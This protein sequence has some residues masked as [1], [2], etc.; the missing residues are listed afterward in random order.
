MPRIARHSLEALKQHVALYDVV[1]PVVSLKRSGRNWVGL[2]P[3]SNEKTPS[4]YVLTDKNIFKCFSSGLAGDAIRFLQETDK[5][6]FVEAIEVLAERFGFQL[7]YESGGEG[8]QEA[9]SRSRDLVAL[10]DYA[11][12]YYHRCLLADTPLSAQTRTYWE[13]R[14][15]LPM[16]LAQTFRI[17]L[18]PPDSPRLV[19]RLLD[20]GF[21]PECLR[22]SGL[23]Y[24]REGAPLPVHPRQWRQRF[25][26]RLMIP[27]RDYLSRTVAFT[28][29]Q[30]EG[31]TPEDDPARE[32]KYINSPETALFDKGRILFNLD[33]A[34][35]ALDGEAAELTW[36][37]GQLDALRCSSVGLRSVVAPQGTAVTEAQLSL[38]K[39]YTRRHRFILDGDRAGRQ[40]A[41]RVLPKALALH[42]DLSVVLLADGE[43]PDS[44][45]RSDPE[46]ALRAWEQTA[47][48]G[49]VYAARALVASA[50]DP[51]ARAEGLQQFFALLLHAPEHSLQ[52]DLLEQALPALPLA[53]EALRRDFEH[54]RAAQGAQRITLHSVPQAN[55]GDPQTPVQQGLTSAEEDLVW[56]FLH[57]PQWAELLSNYLDDAWLDRDTLA[58]RL[59]AA[60]LT[61]ARE[62][63]WEA[64]DVWM[65]SLDDAA[66]R[67]WLFSL[68]ARPCPA[69][70]LREHAQSALQALALRHTKARQQALTAQLAAAQSPEAVQALFEQRRSLNAQCLKGVAIELPP[71]PEGLLT[72]AQN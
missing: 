36:V 56:Q 14:R 15:G 19:E 39:R 61:E 44:L 3:F 65:N 8:R 26:G 37:E 53:P 45:L 63:L 11:A 69:E 1:S 64:P 38:A 27:I 66:A 41:L 54:F 20:K 43:D 22:D 52:Q 62:G 60:I 32:A 68:L 10:H 17:G 18:A 30:L 21:A 48:P 72:T 5:L 12:D 31:I 51:S 28:A 71:V 57:Y 25:R 50:A 7:D 42:L 35:E 46:A 2:S 16:E 70:T 58:C 23:F 59:L 6:S 67:D 13:Q 24:V 9:R 40:A 34:R 49:T 55:E 4:F 29:R 33:R 47:V